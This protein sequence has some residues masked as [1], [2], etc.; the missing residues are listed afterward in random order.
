MKA[1]YI[2]RYGP[3]GELRYGDMPEPLPGKGQL[4]VE[5]HACS[6][7]P[8]DWKIREGQLRFLTGRTFPRILGSDFA[9][10][11]R[12][13]GAGVTGFRPGDEVYGDA[14]LIAGKQ[15]AHAEYAA[16]PEKNM[17][18]KPRTFS[19]QQA[20]SLPIAALTA[21]KTLKQVVI[22]QG[23][24]VLVNGA[25]GGVGTMALQM[26]KLR[27]ARVTAVC[28]ERNADFARSLGADRVLDYAKEDITGTGELYAGIFDA[29][30][31]MDHG[32]AKKILH[33]EGFFISTL[34][35][36]RLV[37]SL[38]LSKLLGGRR[39]ILA[40]ASPTTRDLT[41]I[42]ELCDSGKIRTHIEKTF[43][44][45]EAVEAY[46]MLERGGVRGKVVLSVR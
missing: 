25:T 35:S 27:G 26:A 1:I 37:I 21:H 2:E 22:K 36:A 10:V 38:V 42:A 44:L 32:A 3:I 18:L 30:G 17:A 4:L 11:V 16:V 28:S 41:E 40:A 34:P 23:D 20:A 24:S 19:F 43:S 29:H 8:L 12:T 15:G 14:S 13:A 7:N 46:A 9:G 39:I 31:H 6:V 5:I 45:S 33:P